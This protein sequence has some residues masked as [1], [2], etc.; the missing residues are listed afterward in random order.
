[1]KDIVL[2]I[3]QRKEFYLTVLVLTLLLSIA[4]AF[5]NLTVETKA[6]GFET[7]LD[8]VTEAQLE[9]MLTERADVFRDGLNSEALMRGFLNNYNYMGYVGT[10]LV[11]IVTV[12][13]S[14]FNMSDK[15]TREFM[16]TLPVKRVALELYNYIA[17]I[18]IFLFNV[19]VVTI[20]HLIYFSHING[21]ILT[22]AEKFPDIL[23]AMVPGN[24]VTVNNISLLYQLGMMTLFLYALITVLFLFTTV[25][26]KWAVGLPIGLIF[27]S[28]M[29]EFLYDLRYWYEKDWEISDSFRMK[30][31]VFNVN[32][33]F[34]NYQW[35]GGICTNSYTSY[36]AVVLSVMIVLMIGCMIAHAYFR[37]LSKGKIFYISFLN[38]ILLVFGGFF[39]FVW[40]EDWFLTPTA[41]IITIAAELGMLYFLYHKKGKVYKLAVKEKK[42]IW[43]PIVAQGIKSYLIATGII[44]LITQ[45]ID[46]TSNL[47]YLRH[48]FYDAM[49][50]FDY[51]TWYLEYFKSAYRYQYAMFILL[52]FIVF[53]C[54]QFSMERTKASREFYET[55][56][57]SRIKIYCTKV[58]MDLS[59]IVVPLLVFTC[60]A[61][62]YL[63][64]YNK[65]MNHFR[66]ELDIMT[67]VGDQFL[68]AVTVLCIAICLMG[69]MYLI[70]AVTVS[71]SV[72]NVYCGVA[73]LFI[74]VVTIMVLESNCYNFLYDFVGLLYGDVN[75]VIAMIYLFIGIMLLVAA[76]YLFIRR[77]GA[78]EIFYYAPVKYVFAAMLS[79]CY[80]MFVLA[81]VVAEQS[82]I[83]YFLAVLGT[84]LI[85]ALTLYYCTPGHVAKLQKKVASKRVHK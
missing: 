43:N 3:K 30:V 21:K 33:Y 18:G 72:K 16:E 26:K 29:N 45:V 71:G 12:I 44:I 85:F 66:P 62:G 67:L 9:R 5:Y 42:K 25:F 2:L 31:S 65:L 80:L 13:F 6:L 70:D 50:W 14:Y 73:A 41:I 60:T 8:M 74:F 40:A 15:G 69:A 4:G 32:A 22:L 83:Q 24:L 82:I 81:G 55:L 7:G 11:I 53:K 23:G 37:E 68:L 35:N 75:P 36:A 47:D 46:I 79:F 54:I 61:V 28:S 27:W 76:G 38:I 48:Y 58:L 49:I 1:M 78:K 77:D 19:I 10:V 51:D 34:G 52:G 57:V 17:T 59:V 64:Y 20:I 63:I 56:P 39:F 84:I